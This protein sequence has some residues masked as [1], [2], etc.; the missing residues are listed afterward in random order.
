MIWKKIK[1][2]RFKINVQSN[3]SVFKQ[4]TALFFKMLDYLQKQNF[5]VVVVTV[6]MYKSYLS[7][8]NSKILQRR[9][10]VLTIIEKEYSNVTLFLKEEDTLSYMVYDFKNQSH[11]N[12]KGATV[13]SKQLDSILNKF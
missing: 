11:F 3:T 13:F 7:K 6:P 4:N 9:D 5:Q 12:P 1:N 2:D 8:R 10:S